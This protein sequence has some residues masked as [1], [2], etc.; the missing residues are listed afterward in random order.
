MYR[1]DVCAIFY[2]NHEYNKLLPLT[3]KRS[4]A[5]LPFDC[6][7]R[8]IDFILSM[9]KNA[10]I[11]NTLMILNEDK[12]SSLIDHIG[13]GR[14]WGLDGAGNYCYFLFIQEILRKKSSGKM[15]FDM[16][17]QYLRHSKS[18]YTVLIGNKFLCSLNLKSLIQTHIAQDCKV[19]AVYQKVKSKEFAK[20]D[21]LLI[22]GNDHQIRK[23]VESGSAT[24]ASNNLEM[25][26]FVMDTKWLIKTLQMGQDEGIS[27]NLEKLIMDQMIKD[28]NF[29]YEYTGFLADIHDIASYYQA[30]MKML[31][32]NNFNELI[33]NF[34]K[35]KSCANRNVPTYLGES[36]KISNSQLSS[37]CSIK[38]IVDNSLL[39]SKVKIGDNTKIIDSILYTNVDVG[40]HVKIKN[41]ILDKNVIVKDGVRIIGTKQ[42]PIVIEKGAII[43][44]DQITTE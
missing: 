19:T 42:S 31:N 40:S 36:A 38:G 43:N 14:E 23:Y 7:Y 33:F 29:G 34:Q 28:S 21:N 20:D 25:E 15:Y 37:G 8:V 12:M 9:I 39:S 30:N 13:S 44:D 4:I 24:E 1:S 6:K 35:I 2:D 3:E 5:S 17:I 41:A 16:I 27:S 32:A 22:F 10:D 18:K 11:H 26:V